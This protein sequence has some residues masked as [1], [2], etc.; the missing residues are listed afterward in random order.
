MRINNRLGPFISASSVNFRLSQSVIVILKAG[1]GDIAWNGEW[2]VGNGEWW[3]GSG[4]WRLIPGI[5]NQ[6]PLLKE[7]SGSFCA[8]NPNLVSHYTC[9]LPAI[10]TPGYTFQRTSSGTWAR[11]ERKLPGDSLWIIALFALKVKRWY[12]NGMNMNQLWG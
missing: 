2:W 11:L 7:E 1:L 3:M 5:E 9:L 4:E 6:Q 8:R 10:S 12:D